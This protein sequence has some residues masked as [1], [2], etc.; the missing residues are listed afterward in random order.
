[1]QIIAQ[2]VVCK[3][4]LAHFH[5]SKVSKPLH[6]S[7]VTPTASLATNMA[8]VDPKEME[9][10]KQSSKPK[11]RRVK[12]AVARL[13]PLPED[14]R[15]QMQDELKVIQ[16]EFKQRTT[17]AQNIRKQHTTSKKV[18]SGGTGPEKQDRFKTMY[19]ADF[20][21]KYVTPPECRPTSPTRRHNPHPSRVSIT[22]RNYG[23]LL[24]IIKLLLH[25][26]LFRVF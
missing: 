13:S 17:S 4:I 7:T 10:R 19:S 20:R 5:Q 25:L 21:G 11:R 26:I 8:D 1:M 15:S 3:V 22:V 14:Q 16:K 24:T 6:Q 18:I 9:E 23:D 12:S 2:G